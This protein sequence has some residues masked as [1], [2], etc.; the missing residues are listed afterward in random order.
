MRA[1]EFINEGRLQI[2]VPNEEWLQ[3]KIDYAKRKSRNEFGVPAMQ[4]T[5]AYLPHEEPI[6]LP[7]K[8]LKQIPG[9]R[10]EQQRVRSKD[11][12][13]IMKIMQDTGKLPLTDRGTEYHPFILVGYDGQPWVFEGNHRIMAAAAL[14]WPT[15]KVVVKYFDGGER[16]KSGLLYPPKIGLA[17]EE[18]LYE[19]IGDWRKWT[20]GAAVA[21]AAALGGYQAM[22]QP[23]QPVT[24]PVVQ[25]A[26]ELPVKQL[27]P[28][29]RVLVAAAQQAGLEG[30]ELKQFLAQCAHETGNFTHLEELGS[31]RYLMKKYDKK[32]SPKKAKELGNTQVGDG[33]RYKGRGYIQLTGRYNYKR[34]G[35]ALGLPLEQRPELVE[36]PEIAAKV[37]LWFWAQRV[38]PRVQDFHDVPQATKPINPALKGLQSRQQHYDKYQQVTLP[39]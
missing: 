2:D 27:K 35:Q 12:Q 29:E 26:P 15:L 37:S 19:G 3:G 18:E 38:Q 21:G 14:G 30:N 5:T 25:P 9:A 11:L 31:D 13:A 10:G 8:L 20:A 1:N 22:K 23:V 24:Q 7:V 32:F 28:L 36:N 4:S 39:K 33:V 17:T 6:E 34:A 16:I